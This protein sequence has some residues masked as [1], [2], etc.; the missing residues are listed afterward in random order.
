MLQ[1]S[2][3]GLTQYFRNSPF[4]Y[5]PSLPRSDEKR[6]IGFSLMPWKYGRCLAWN[7]T[8]PDWI[9]S[10]GNWRRVSKTQ[11]VRDHQP[12]PLFRSNSCRDFG[13]YGWR[14]NS[15]SEIPGWTHRWS[16]NRTSSCGVLDVTNQCNHPARQCS[17]YNMALH[18]LQPQLN[19]DV[20]YYIA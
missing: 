16:Y 8:S 20:I 14:G 4:I 11:Q 19:L 5:S 9:G 3:H 17:V 15:F 6:L 13:C 18:G 12:D 2:Y 1:H 10:C 7:V